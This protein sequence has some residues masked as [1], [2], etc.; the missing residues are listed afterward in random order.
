MKKCIATLSLFWICVGLVSAEEAAKVDQKRLTLDR[1]FQA[2]EFDPKSAP[3]FQWS[4][5][6]GGYTTLDKPTDGGPGRDVVWH[7]PAAGKTEV[8]VPAHRFVP[9]GDD[10]ALNIEHYTFSSDESKLLIF[11]N[12][13][14]VWRTRTRGDYWVL[15]VNTGELKKLGGDAPRST[16]MFAKFSPDGTKVGYV[17]ENN[18]YVQDLQSLHVTQLTA[19]GSPKR[20]NGTFDWVYEEELNLQDGFRWSPDGRS[21]AYWQ[22]DDEGVR[23]IHL[24]NSL[25]SLYP[26]LQSIP[27]PKVGE[28]NP[29]ARI[30]IVGVPGGAT[31]WIALPE[32]PRDHY[33]AQMDWAGDSQ[34][35]IFQQF[36]R[37]QNTDRLMTI[38]LESGAVRTMLTERDA[39][40]I[41]NSNHTLSWFENYSKL[42]WLSERDGWQHA[43]FVA[44]DSGATT[45]IT[46]GQFDVV[47]VEGVD[48]KDGW[49]Y[50]IASPENPTQRYLYRISFD[51]TKTER[52]TPANLPGTHSYSISPDAKWAMHTYST[53]MKPPSTSLISLPDH[54]EVSKIVDNQELEKKLANLNQTAT[55]FFRVPVEG[56]VQLDAW[57]IKPPN[58]DEK[59]KYPVL[60]YVYGEP[61][62]QTV[63]DRWGGKRHLWHL[64][65]AQEGYV[66]IS[67]D[68]HGTPAPRGRDWR[69]IVYRQ[70]GVLSS[71]DQAQAAQ[72]ILKDRPYL[73]PNRVAIWGWSGGGSMTLNMIF[74]Y[75]DIYKAAISVAPVPNQ[76]LYDSIYQER[77][78][79]LPG[80]N[81]AGYRQGSPITFANQLKGELMVIHGTGDDNVHFQGTE[82]LINELIAHNKQVE[83]FAYPSRTHAI[84]E[85][86]NTTR[87]LYGLMTRFLKQKV[88]VE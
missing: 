66:V 47:S 16:L 70:I 1:V 6:R 64:L 19:D 82:T 86:K 39:A 85:R 18:L 48:T 38:D 7:D 37:L 55:E 58:F 36:N 43:Y 11:T 28:T 69:K 17:R 80:D 27:Y 30:G 24:V 65:L 83:M 51:G 72:R 4:S 10:A 75:P 50:Y 63:L 67:V 2:N 3:A 32:D 76:R 22:I 79:G 56:D 25:D 33:L 35:L 68:N 13:K 84:A 45:L 62:G 74:R 41:E 61:A 78:M 57:C 26:E 49:L 60:F 46:A 44:K 52:L 53:F 40:W 14:R 31:T 21:I 71:A 34:H 9:A 12:S 20:I 88:P 87:H 59:K 42:L 73:D 15:D 81:A 23:E 77:Y 29:S 8:L 54:R 5:R